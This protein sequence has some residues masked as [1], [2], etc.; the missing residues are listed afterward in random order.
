MNRALA[1]MELNA[2]ERAMDK[3]GVHAQ[4]MKADRRPAR[5]GRRVQQQIG[6]FCLILLVGVTVQ[7]ELGVLNEDCV[8]TIL[9]RQTQ[10]SAN[11]TFALGNVPIPPGPI[12]ARFVCDRDTLVETAQSDFVFG[13]PNGATVF[14]G[15]SFSQEEQVPVSIE[16]AAPTFTLTP[17]TIT[18]Q[19]IVFAHFLDGR[20]TIGDFKRFLRNALCLS[21]VLAFIARKTSPKIPSRL[22]IIYSL[23]CK[24]IQ[25]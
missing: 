6:L 4:G 15:I 3:C 1:F 13:V 23:G 20:A 2:Q 25:K 24:N 12:R 16:I 21:V 5:F 8:V 17:E 10:V 14:P 9:N 11:G 19:L 18:S 22:L 7:A